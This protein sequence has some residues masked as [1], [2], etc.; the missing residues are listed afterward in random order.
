MKILYDRNMA[1]GKSLFGRLGDARPCDGRALTRRDLADT[2]L[3]FVRS[4][5]KLDADLLAGTPVRFVGSGVAGTDHIDFEALRRLG[6]T[7]ATAP[8]CNAE[9]VAD[10]FVSALLTLGAESGNTWAGK[11]LGVVGVGH[12]G[13]IVA[14]FAEDALGMNVLRCDPPRKEREYAASDFVDLDA[15]LPQSDVITFHT[16][17]TDEGPDATR[18]LFSG[19]RVRL[20]KPG[21]V[22][23]NLARGPVCDNALLAAM[24]TTG[25]LSDLVIDC[26]EGEPDYSPEL[27]A[28]A[29][30]AS[31]HIA[32]HAYEG[33]AD[34]TYAVYKAACDFLGV[35]AGRRPAYPAPAVPRLTLDCA[36]RSDEAVLHAATAA[37]CD[38]RAEDARFRAAFSPSPQGRREAFDRLRKTVLHRRLF[39]ATTLVLNGASPDLIRKL[40]VLGFRI[41]RKAAAD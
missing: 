39:S 13:S 40:R 41:G 18:G 25:L 17:L 26:W 29:T 3:L 9:S 34:G 38:T 28:L 10:W 23:F 32:G 4:T 36:G 22:L 31:P 11:T 15:L 30:L 8:G 7:V 2:D 35:P 12:V 19:P 33:R 37:C 20:T 5:C 16:P 6:I 27:A 24:A 14:R 21:A 1:H